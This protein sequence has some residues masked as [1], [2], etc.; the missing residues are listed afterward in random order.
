MKDKQR[1]KTS[2]S[3]RKAETLKLLRELGLSMYNKMDN[4]VFPDIAFPS[5]SVRNLVY[6]DELRQ[7]I[8]GAN[9]VT[10][11]SQNIKGIRPFT[12]IVWLAFFV[13]KLLGQGKTSTL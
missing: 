13:E 8:L 10:R 7:Y 5:R 12:H 11:S 1:S 6:D 2:A 3:I 4:G 9:R